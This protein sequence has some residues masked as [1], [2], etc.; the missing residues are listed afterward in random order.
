MDSIVRLEKACKILDCTRPTIARMIARGDLP[1]PVKI[2]SRFVFWTN[3][4]FELAMKRLR[5]KYQQ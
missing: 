3:A 2:N 4:N 1:P 5:R